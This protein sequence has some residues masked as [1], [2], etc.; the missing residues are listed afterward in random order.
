MALLMV[1]SFLALVP[2]GEDDAAS[3][4]VYHGQT[5]TENNRTYH[6]I[7]DASHKRYTD[8][9]FPGDKDVD[10]YIIGSSIGDRAFEGCTRL[11]Y[12]V[13]DDS[14]KTIGKYA[15]KDSSVYFLEGP[16]VTAIGD[17]AFQGSGL[18]R[19][20]AGSE[21]TSIGTGAFMGT[22]RLE[23]VVT[24]NT[25][26]TQ[27]GKDTFR[28][29]GIDFIDLWNMTSIDP[30][31]FTGSDLKFQLVRSE[32]SPHA[33]G[34]SRIICPDSVSERGFGEIGCSSTGSFQIRMSGDAE[35]VNIV[36]ADG[37]SVDVRAHGTFP[38]YNDFELK[39]GND[40]Y[41]G[42]DVRVL[43]PGEGEPIIMDGSGAVTLPTLEGMGDL[44]FLGWLIDGEGE[45]V[46]Q[47]SADDLADLK[48][49]IT[50]TPKYGTATVTFDH[51]SI[52]GL[53]DTSA[54]ASSMDFT[55]GD[56]YPHPGAATGY[57]FGGWEID[58]V[59]TVQPGDGVAIHRDH[60]ATA[61]WTSERTFTVQYLGTDGG[62]I[63]TE[64]FAY[65]ERTDVMGIVPE[66]PEG[67]AFV[68]WSLTEAGS[69][70]TTGTEIVVTSDV[71]MHPILRD[72]PKHTVSFVSL[73]EEVHS[74]EAYEGSD[75]EVIEGPSAEWKVFLH[76]VD[77]TGSE[78][79]SG[80]YLNVA[81]DMTL[82]AVFTEVETA[83]VTYHGGSGA[84]EERH[85]LGTE[86]SVDRVLVDTEDRLFAGWSTSL[87]DTEPDYV[88]GD[89][90]TVT[91]DID[92]YPVW[93]ERPDSTVTFVDG[94]AEVGRFTVGH[95]ESFTIPEMGLEREGFEFVGWS[96]DPSSSEAQHG[97]G[98]TF[99]PDGETV[100]HA[101]WEKV[102]VHVITFMDGDYRVSFHGV[103]DGLSF[104]IPAIELTRDGC[105]FVGWSLE[106]GSDD[107]DHSVGHTLSPDGDVTLH[108]VWAEIASHTVT[109]MDGSD[110][111]CTREAEDGSLVST[112]GV[113]DGIAGWSSSPGGEA[114]YAA[115]APVMPI[116][117]MTLY[118]VHPE[119]GT[120]LLKYMDGGRIV[121]S[122]SFRQG[123][124]IALDPDVHSRDGYRLAG[125][126]ADD[127]GAGNHG[128]GGFGEPRIRHLR[129]CGMGEGAHGHL[130]GRRREA[131]GA[132][133]GRR[134]ACGDHPAPGC[135]VPGMEPLGRQR[136]RLRGGGLLRANGG[137]RAL[138][139]LGGEVHPDPAERQPR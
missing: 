62:A 66:V 65:G 9:D 102:V 56:V 133:R 112:A 117:D 74:V 128:T 16:R 50:L 14:V 101:V 111:I 37:T 49:T 60:T 52:E 41:L 105:R 118:A 53:T 33:E 106:P 57:V 79:C 28:D 89:R 134:W 124:S 88:S 126:S 73:G 15:F 135:G 47:I 22:D 18:W 17:Y 26:V 103:M 95:G 39:I 6:V 11:N 123:E 2:A 121:G 132:D 125:W 110:V 137:H 108:A 13:L 43:L 51:S 84:V 81:E 83:V 1:V 116:S 7:G 82:T 31:A 87:G 32:G 93:R 48:S 36:R 69:T 25:S 136:G 20:W 4:D 129:A 63:H 21:L 8:A 127:G 120:F 34:V 92:L 61:V 67:M 139:R 98:G 12:V 55:V 85:A 30:T 68:G 72:V 138:L 107:A 24:W 70:V 71:T 76:W 77:G 80:D 115:G 64:T 3:R 35:K 40:Y 46:L 54:L 91:A 104:T 130:H 59:G 38:V 109:F 113:L 119:P 94:G 44:E 27:I 86:I 90:F 75:V 23:D 10:I 131:V 96:Q 122:V 114:E 45:P 42:K 5:F 100:L 58:G 19:I 97:V 99:V 29:S 78:Y